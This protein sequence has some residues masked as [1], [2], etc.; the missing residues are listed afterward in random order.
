LC[1]GLVDWQA[2]HQTRKKKMKALL[3]KIINAMKPRS[4]YYPHQMMTDELE[5]ELTRAYMGTGVRG[6]RF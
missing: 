2:D 1:L 5:R 4:H 6:R 3:Q